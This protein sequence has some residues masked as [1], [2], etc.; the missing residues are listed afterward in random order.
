VA[1]EAIVDDIFGP[2]RTA[3]AASVSMAGAFP[4]ELQRS[5]VSLGPQSC[6]AREHAK[7]KAWEEGPSASSTSAATVDDD[8]WGPPSENQSSEFGPAQSHSAPHVV[9]VAPRGDAH[10]HFLRG[11]VLWP[12]A[13]ALQLNKPQ[14]QVNALN[15]AAGALKG[16]FSSAGLLCVR[17]LSTSKAV[18][19]KACAGALRETGTLFVSDGHSCERAMD[20]AARVVDLC[21]AQRICSYRR[22]CKQ[23]RLRHQIRPYPKPSL[24]PYTCCV[25][26]I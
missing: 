7:R 14:E 26:I 17:G 20:K 4:D 11:C 23:H 16:R 12:P 6:T 15:T 8:L 18:Y 24:R 10:P 13:S 2:A 25:Q 5:V 22:D 21:A 1:M 3:P 19:G 9:T